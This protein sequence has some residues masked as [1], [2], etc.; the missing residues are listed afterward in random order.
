[1]KNMS[2]GRRTTDEKIVSTIE[3]FERISFYVL[4]SAAFLPFGST[5]P[6]TTPFYIAAGF[7]IFIYGCVTYLKKSF[8]QWM[9]RDRSADFY[10]E[11]PWKARGL[12]LINIIHL[13]ET[14]G[15]YSFL[16]MWLMPWGSF[17]LTHHGF[18]MAI[19][20]ALFNNWLITYLI[21]KV[22]AWSKR[23]SEVDSSNPR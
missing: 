10:Q 7:G 18:Y 15:C 5:D 3:K 21:N 11:T 14:H 4:G 17:S 1:M 13:I 20:M 2:S 6:L 16:F 12:K 19:L 23:Q 22:R 9:A 8:R